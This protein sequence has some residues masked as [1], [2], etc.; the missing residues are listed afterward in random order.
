MNRVAGAV[1]VLNMD[2]SEDRMRAMDAELSGKGILYERLPAI[3]GRQL[4]NEQVRQWSTKLCSYLCTPSMIGCFLTHMRAWAHV[5][6]RNIQNAIVLED[7]VK[8]VDG[9]ENTFLSA[10]AALPVDYDFMYLGCF[11]CHRSHPLDKVLRLLSGTR[12]RRERVYK[13]GVPSPH[14]VRPDQTLGTHSYMV[15]L[16]GARAALKALPRAS[17]HVDWALSGL[18]DSLNVYAVRPNLTY[19]TDAPS[20]IG[21]SAPVLLNA[22]ASNFTYLSDR[23]WAWILSEPV[24]ALGHPTLTI[25]GWVILSILLVAWKPRLFLP[26]FVVEAVAGVLTGT[27]SGY[28]I[29]VGLVLAGRFA[30]RPG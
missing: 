12:R 24:C 14:L 16:K 21:G 13:D 6:D 10:C 17:F 23:T 5:V 22:V 30:A 8:I 26:L 3:D 1:M 28:F 4:T 19:Q 29:I 11:T 25:D 18:I 9:Y 20:T 2:R 27:S 7:D 15:S